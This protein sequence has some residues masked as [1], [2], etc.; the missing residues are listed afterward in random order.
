[1]THPRS[2]VGAGW[3]AL[4]RGQLGQLRSSASEGKKWCC[5]GCAKGH[6]GAVGVKTKEC[7]GC[8]LKQ[9]TFGLPA[10]GKKGGAAM[11]AAGMAT[12]LVGANGGR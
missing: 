4:D 12:T 11:A 2:A 1:M 7:A 6:K 5:S 9:P 8:Q 10:E 3:R